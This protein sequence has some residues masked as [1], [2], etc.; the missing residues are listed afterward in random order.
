[1]DRL[2]KRFSRDIIG[3]LWVA[4]GIFLAL[5]LYSYLPAD[6]SFN[7]MGRTAPV[8]NYCGYFGSFL[9]DLIFQ[10]LGLSGWI[11]PIA[12]IRQSVK[13]FRGE[14]TKLGVYSLILAGL[15]LTTL[16]SL[17]SLYLPDSLWYGDQVSVGGVLGATVT[18]YL[19]G[20]FNFAGVSVILWTATLAFMVFY[21]ERSL[22]DLI[23]WPILTTHFVFERLPL[24]ESASLVFNVVAGSLSKSWS[25]IW[26]RKQQRPV[27]VAPATESPTSRFFPIDNNFEDVELSDLSDAEADEDPQPKLFSLKKV[28]SQAKRKVSLKKKVQRKIENWEL[29][30]LSL[31]A[32]PPAS[33][34]KVDDK[35]IKEK[36]RLLVNKME[37]FSVRGKVTGAKPGPAVTM[38]EFKPNVDV[39][40]SKITDLADDLSLALSSE[41]VRIIAPIPGR[42]VVGIET[43]NAARETVY[44]K[45]ILASDEFWDEDIKLPLALGCQADGTQKVVDLRKMPHLLVAGSTGSGKSVFVVSILT[46]LLFRHSPKTLRLVLV[47]PKQVDL[48]AFNN[49]PHLLMP[50]IR[51]AKKA[52]NALRWAIKEMEKRYRSMAKFG[53][54]GLEDFNSAVEEL[55]SQ[56]IKEHEEFNEQLEGRGILESYYFTP[57][58][59]IAVVVE[60]FGDLMAVDKSNVEQAVVRL[61]QMARAS[62]IHLI[63]A[64]QSPRKDV[65]TGLIKTNIPGRVSFKVAS[66]MDSRIILDESGAERLLSRGDMLFLAPGVSKPQRHHGPWLTDKEINLVTRTWT[67]QAEPEFDALAMRALEGSGGGFDLPGGQDFEVDD[68]EFDDRYD[69]ILAYVS[70]QKAVSASL[71]QR[72][73]RIGYP[74]AARLIEVFESEGVVGPP[75]GS[76]PRQVLVSE[77]K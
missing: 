48:A 31:L 7:S 3:L 65:V 77:L 73:F 54:R 71:I 27:V 51:D 63:L 32:D 47:D 14:S 70:T 55:S 38:F 34:F 66:K 59:Y 19:V 72:R 16:S 37:Q 56:V 52:I 76:K 41:S 15:L 44:L 43:S 61:A 12:A 64:M 26:H 4:T 67:E 39:K 29:P 17:G 46:G 20:V 10:F 53:A 50:P 68:E 18:K 58:P 22:K 62:G 69:E 45:D 8:H 75:N 5:S 40:I 28:K 42:D 11:L 6:P 13:G 36:G 1:M 9:A 35:E 49:I 25:A 30:K 57:Q 33:R 24:L 74:R 21:T 2:F 60:E 23:H